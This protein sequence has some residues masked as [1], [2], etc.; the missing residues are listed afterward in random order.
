MGPAIELGRSFVRAEYQKN[1]WALLLLWRGIAKVV[2]RQPRYRHLFGVVSI[3]ADYDD[4]TKRLLM[5]FLR[6]NN[7][8][9]RLAG[10]VVPR[11]PARLRRSQLDIEDFVSR[12]A[13]D[14]D[15]VDD[16]VREIEH[17]H[18]AVPVLLRQYLRLNA[19]VL[20]FNIDPAF[21]NVLDALML[22]DLTRVHRPILDRFFGR[23][24]AQQFLDHHADFVADQTLAS[25][26]RALAVAAH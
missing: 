26:R 15:D 22:I 12:V 19:R 9:A 14:I 4:T 21:G 17:G 18:R 13:H 8:D 1:Y 2:S 24:A 6:L 5:S 25:R 3:S 7:F 10:L 23:K 20:G 11:T 16:L